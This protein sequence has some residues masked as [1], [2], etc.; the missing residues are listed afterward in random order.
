MLSIRET[1]KTQ[2]HRNVESKR[3]KKTQQANINQNKARVAMLI[4]MK[5]ALKQKVLVRI[6]RVNK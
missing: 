2:R 5:K 1:S 4:L 3:Y 6:T